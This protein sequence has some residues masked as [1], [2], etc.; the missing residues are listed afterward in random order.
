M[1]R[2]KRE[3]RKK[4]MEERLSL[5]QEKIINDIKKQERLVK[6]YENVELCKEKKKIAE[7]IHSKKFEEI[8]I[9][10]A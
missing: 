4:L 7:L 9:M 5:K 2:K 6:A 8:D 1:I 3:E 10:I